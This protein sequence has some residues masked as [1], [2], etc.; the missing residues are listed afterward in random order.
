VDRE[1]APGDEGPGTGAPERPDLTADLNALAA[2]RSRRSA[3]DR[4]LPALDALLGPEATADRET[5]FHER[6]RLVDAAIA[7]VADPSHRQAAAVLLGTGPLRWHTLKERG[8]TAAASF[9]VSWEGYRH[10]RADGSS[11]RTDTIDA[12][13]TS[14]RRL[15]AGADPATPPGGAEPA[16]AS[17]A[18][19]A[20][21]PTAAAGTG[22]HGG[23]DGA[24]GNGSGG[25]P[26]RGLRRALPS[27]AERRSGS[28]AGAV[29]V[30]VVALVVLAALAVV[31]RTT[32]RSTATPP[33]C[34][35]RTY[36]I[37][38]VG[39]DQVVADGWVRRF[40]AFAG[41]DAA[42]P[43][44]CA[45]PLRSSSD[46]IVFQEVTDGV[47]QRTSAL[48]GVEDDPP[49][50]IVVDSFAIDKILDPGVEGHQLGRPLRRLD[51]PEPQ[52]AIEFTDGIL[53]REAPSGRPIPLLGR[54]YEEWQRLGGWEGLGAP[55]SLL[56]SKAGV[57]RVQVFR[58]GR[59]VTDFD[60]TMTNRPNPTPEPPEVL[61]GVIARVDDGASWWVDAAGTR[62]WLT[63]SCA[64]DMVRRA[65]GIDA[66][67][68]DAV[69]VMGLE[70]GE[71]VR[72]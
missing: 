47:T 1:E 28:A 69:D 5:R 55:V 25:G 61:G 44:R 46:R 36:R 32:G 42:R 65:Q 37:G 52:Q 56:Y 63:S 45:G 31:W 30:G 11:L 51:L 50:V 41:T 40:E 17:D 53:Y 34:D 38:E 66:T 24:G 58:N 7:A 9:N 26:A 22:G 16:G 10:R 70:I 64:F 39:V 72:C 18:A 62:H 49:G 13:A 60:G 35:A 67:T 20:R 48:L 43:F 8:A 6:Q 33:A 21:E 54:H 4:A 68:W 29:L 14:L 3:R 19:A 12:V 71:E 15:A 59:L 57:G 2:I 23:N 27:G